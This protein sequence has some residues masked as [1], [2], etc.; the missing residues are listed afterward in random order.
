MV[1]V[2]RSKQAFVGDALD[3]T[4]LKGVGQEPRRKKRSSR[5][6]P[7]LSSQALTTICQAL[8]GC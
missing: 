5:R 8:A 3:S 4:G 6:G 1:Q 2:G 7:Y